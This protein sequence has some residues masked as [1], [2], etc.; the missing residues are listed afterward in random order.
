MSRVVCRCVVVATM[1]AVGWLAVLIHPSAGVEPSDTLR[2]VANTETALAVSASQPWLDDP[3]DASRRFTGVASCAAGN[4]HGGA[5]SQGVV[6][7]EYQVWI[8]QDPHARAY[9][10]L[11]SD[12]SIRMSQLLDLTTM[13]GA[14]MADGQ[15]RTAAH[16]AKE[17]L[18]C[19][20]TNSTPDSVADTHFLVPEDGVGCESCHGAAEKWL[21]PHVQFDW[22]SRS[23]GDKAA[24]GFRD[25]KNVLTRARVCAECHVGMPGREVNHDLIAAGHPRLFFEF[26]AF[27]VNLPP[28]WKRDAD[29]A[30]A[31]LD[32]GAKHS[33]LEAK[34][35][36]VGQVASAEAALA[37]LESRAATANS[38][39]PELAEYDCFACHHDLAV[40]SWRLA[41]GF[42]N[43][44]PGS[45]PWSSWYFPL[46]ATA[47]NEFGGPNLERAD[48]PLTGLQR[49][50][51]QFDRKEAGKLAR[52][53]RIELAAWANKLDDPT[54][55]AQ[56]YSTGKLRAA[57]RRLV[58]DGPAL[59]AQN[60]DAATQLYLALAAVH[61]GYR[62]ALYG[63]AT[64]PTDSDRSI[65][66]AVQAV[67]KQLEYPEHFNSPKSFAARPVPGNPVDAIREQLKRIEQTLAPH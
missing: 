59:A 12:L 10:V 52:A 6:G 9:T 7:S 28:H 60:W 56:L 43:G 27:H 61:Q 26:S 47:A 34:L 51:S 39:W 14:T 17:C 8:Q 24:L 67:R 31:S 42:G 64:R 53:L 18:V 38:T 35:W 32:G 15:A 33:Y 22:G 37:L 66:D 55:A 5:G 44:R 46:L 19:H 3:A 4:C 49:A 54:S 20:A 58:S 23:S 21:G 41:R 2:R 62:D 1:I 45:L 63:V 25:T 11:F 36:A 65:I 57:L 13:Y 16:Q 29:N 30:R 48:S 50:M 40:P